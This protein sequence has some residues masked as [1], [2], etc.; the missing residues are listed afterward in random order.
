VVFNPDLLERLAEKADT[1]HIML[2]SDYPFAEWKPVQFVQ[3]AKK[4]PE[5]RR[6][7]IMGANAAKFLG[8]DI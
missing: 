3:R 8:V 6:R 1:S 5:A 2:G 7:A 4:I